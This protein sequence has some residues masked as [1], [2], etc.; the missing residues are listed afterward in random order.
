MFLCGQSFLSTENRHAVKD[1]EYVLF[2]QSSAYHILKEMTK[3][4]CLF[5]E[6]IASHSKDNETFLNFPRAECVHS[7]V[8]SFLFFSRKKT[9]LYCRSSLPFSGGEVDQ[10]SSSHT[11]FGINNFRILLLLYRPYPQMN[12]IYLWPCHSKDTV[13][14]P[15]RYFV[16]K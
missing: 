13:E 6:T 8:E 11:S 16:T 7:W 9:R 14:L 4:T 2:L 15:L 10:M 12:R 5:F 3:V 1:G